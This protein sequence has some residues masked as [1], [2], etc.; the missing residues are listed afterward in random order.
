M[1]LYLKYQSVRLNIKLDWTDNT[2]ALYRKGDRGPL[3]CRATP[4]D[5]FWLVLWHQPFSTERSAGAAASW[6]LTGR[7]LD[8]LIKRA[9][10]VLGWTLHPVQV[11]GKRGMLAEIL[12]LMESDS[13]RLQWQAGHTGRLCSA[14]MNCCCSLTHFQLQY[15]HPDVHWCN[16]FIFICSLLFLLL[17]FFLLPLTYF[18]TYYYCLLLMLI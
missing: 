10:C 4:G 12:S 3:E 6:L 8:K 7:R 18:I 13:H 1:F 9:G 14:Q 5:L 15:Q 16:C 11:E 17:L 2:N